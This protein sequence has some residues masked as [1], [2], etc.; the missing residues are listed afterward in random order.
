[1][2]DREA[3]TVSVNSRVMLDA[4]FFRKM[5]PNYTRPQPNELLRNETERNRYFE[6]YSE[7]SSEESP[8]RIKGNGVK[9]TNIEEKDLFICCSTVSGFSL[10]DKLWSIIVFLLCYGSCPSNLVDA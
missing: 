3:V 1:M 10:E 2:K 8:D 5:N 6:Y 7:S 4:A 9:S